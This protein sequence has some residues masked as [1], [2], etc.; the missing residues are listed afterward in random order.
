MNWQHYLFEREENLTALQMAARAAMIFIITLILIR[1]GGVRIFGKKS[2]VDTIILIVMGSVLARG[3]V[4]ASS[5]WPVVAAA[6]T[7]IIIHHVLAFLSFKNKKMEALI[8]GSPTVLYAKGKILYKNLHKKSLSEAD[9]MES[10]R[11]ETKKTSLEDIETA[12]METNGRISFIE[13]KKS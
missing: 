7:M 6:G 3:I 12:F 2:A 13:K 10:L 5:I 9:L 1:I 8:K 11:L 4:G